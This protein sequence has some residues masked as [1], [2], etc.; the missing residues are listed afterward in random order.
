MSTAS[1]ERSTTYAQCTLCEAHCGIT[2]TVGGN[3]SAPDGIRIT[4][5]PE[6]AMSRGYICPKASALADLHSDPDRLRTPVQPDA[7]G[8]RADRVGRGDPAGRGWPAGRPGASRDGRLGDVS[9]QPGCSLR[10]GDRRRAR[11]PA[12]RQPQQLFRCLDGSASSAPG[13]PRDVRPL[14]ALPVPDLERTDHLLIFGANPAVSNG[15]IMTAPGMRERLR[16]IR[17]RGRVVVVDPRRTETVAPR[18]RARG[19]RAG[20]RSLPAARDAPCDLRRGTR[21]SGPARGPAV[22]GSRSSVRWLRAGVLSGPHRW[23]ASTRLPSPASPVS[24]PPPSAPS[25]TVVSASAS[26]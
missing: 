10:S 6:D 18:L 1:A 5:D 9:R 16:A 22:T 13:G 7:R 19:G 15:S 2:V 11:A 25:P 20:R 12:D 3:G 14:R 26:R 23:P 17:D 4:G 21:S 8:V 24:S